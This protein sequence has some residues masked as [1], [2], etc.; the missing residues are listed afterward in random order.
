MLPFTRLVERCSSCCSERE[1]EKKRDMTTTIAGRK[2]PL[3]MERER[4]RE[5]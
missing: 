1:K 2:T 5:T 4:K 3:S